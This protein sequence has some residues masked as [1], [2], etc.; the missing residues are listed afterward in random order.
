MSSAP[1]QVISENSLGPQNGKRKLVPAV[2]FDLLS[3]PLSQPLQIEARQ[4]IRRMGGGSQSHLM[5]CSDGHYYVLKLQGNPQGDR[6]LVNELVCAVLAEHLGLPIPR[7]AIVAVPNELIRESREMYTE[8]LWG[9]AAC[10][11]GLCF[12]SRYPAAET[13][14]FDMWPRSRLEDLKNLKDIA[15]ILAFD[16]WTSNLDCRQLRFLQTSSGCRMTM[17]DNGD[18]FGRSNWTFVDKPRF[19]MNPCLYLY[20]HI[21]SM[22]AFEPWLS[23]IEALSKKTISSVAGLVPSEWYEDCDIVDLNNLLEGLGERRTRVR[24]LLISL[25]KGCP[26]LFP[27]WKISAAAGA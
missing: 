1:L 7:S 18:A 22:D 25:S 5:G 23:G 3:P 9:R 2:S 15:G 4:H 17:F 20:D 26:K 8:L 27:A 14:V 10:R 6:M 11:P 13:A 24:S 21:D 12:G 19:L 16:I